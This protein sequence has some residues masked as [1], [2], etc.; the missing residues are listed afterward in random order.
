MQIEAQL[1]LKTLHFKGRPL[2]GDLYQSFLDSQKRN[3]QALSG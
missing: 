2:V 3:K 1:C